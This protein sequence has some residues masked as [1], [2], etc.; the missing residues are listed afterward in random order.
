[1]WQSERISHDK[2][3]EFEIYIDSDGLVKIRRKKEHNAK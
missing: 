1:M 3:N 2:N